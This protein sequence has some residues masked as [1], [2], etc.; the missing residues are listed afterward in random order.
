MSLHGRFLYDDSGEPIRFTGVSLDITDRKAVEEVARAQEEHERR[1]A[2]TLQKALLPSTLRRH[3]SIDMEVRYRAADV[4]ASVGGDWYDTFEWPDGKIGLV[5]GDV[6][7]LSIESAATMGRLRAAAAALATQLP[8]DPGVFLEALDAFARGPDGTDFAT[9]M[10]LIVD[11]NL[12]TLT[13]SLAGDPPPIVVDSDGRSGLLDQALSVPLCVGPGG[14]RPTASFTL[15]PGALSS[16]TP[17]AWS[18]AGEYRSRTA[19][20]DSCNA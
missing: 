4:L 9:A 14:H 17:T 2:L 5:V 3:P 15:Q 12:G 13:Y 1:V 11:T 7:G 19:S 6:V 20:I 8:P 16:P 18:N 10:C